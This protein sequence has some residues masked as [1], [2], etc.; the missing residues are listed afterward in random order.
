M[1]IIG[2]L[3][4]SNAAKKQ[5]IIHDCFKSNLVSIKW[6]GK[7]QAEVVPQKGKATVT[8]HHNDLASCIT[9]LYEIV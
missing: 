8:F 2:S 5:Q 7:I 1:N 9:E 3:S 4:K 6:I